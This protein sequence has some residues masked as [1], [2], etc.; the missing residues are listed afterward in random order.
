MLPK[1]SHLGWTELHQNIIQCRAHVNEVVEIR[2]PKK[3]EYFFTSCGATSFRS[4]TFC[5]LVLGANCAID[6]HVCQ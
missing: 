1:A 4:A 3:E 2:A 5:Y 6:L